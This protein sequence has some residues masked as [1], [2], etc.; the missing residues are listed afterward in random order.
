MAVP[1]L[2]G[3]E[4]LAGGHAPDKYSLVG[5]FQLGIGHESTA[6]GHG[7]SSREVVLPESRNGAVCPLLT[8]RERKIDDWKNILGR[9]SGDSYAT[10][11][12]AVRGSMSF[13][14]LFYIWPTQ[15][16]VN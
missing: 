10:L 9:V 11:G 15:G 7:V 14:V 13:I 8:W 2:Q 4:F 5:L 3:P 12:L 16:T 1:G 6:C